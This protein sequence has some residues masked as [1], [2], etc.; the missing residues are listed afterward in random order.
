M[1]RSLRALIPYLLR[2]RWRYAAGFL[3][4]F[5]KSVF[6]AAIP[7]FIKQAV[8]AIAGGEVGRELWIIAGALLAVAAIN[9]RRARLRSTRERPWTS[10]PI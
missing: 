1:L 5:F 3:A 2:Y 6:A 10:V 4:L 8:D 9:T 7:I